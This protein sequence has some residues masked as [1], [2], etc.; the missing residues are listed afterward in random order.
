MPKMKMKLKQLIEGQ[1]ALQTFISYTVKP[2]FGFM[3]KRATK[4]AIECL[5]DYLEAR[6]DIIK[7]Y[8]T[9]DAESQQPVVLPGT[10]NAE[11]AEKEIKDLI[12]ADIEFS[13]QQI[14]ESEVD[15]HVKEVPSDVLLKLDW[16]FAEGKKGK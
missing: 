16:L 3:V 10:K 11:K 15:K 12:E 8:G 6:A 14:P 5:K 13:V 9:I 2:K 1:G 7:K 4:G